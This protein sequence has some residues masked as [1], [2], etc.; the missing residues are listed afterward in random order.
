MDSVFVMAAAT[1]TAAAAAAIA[2]AMVGLVIACDKLEH[3][4]D[5]TLLAQ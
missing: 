5:P 3:S 2:L 1:A 4:N